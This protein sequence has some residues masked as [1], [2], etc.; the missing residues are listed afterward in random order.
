MLPSRVVSRT[1]GTVSAEQQKAMA[2]LEFVRDMADR[3]L[4]LNTI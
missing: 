2:G 4:P 1:Y 3:T